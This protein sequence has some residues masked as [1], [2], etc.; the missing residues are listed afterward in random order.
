MKRQRIDITDKA[1]RQ[2]TRMDQPQ[3]L[4]IRFI[5]RS[6]DWKDP[7][8]HMVFELAIATYFILKKHQPL[9]HADL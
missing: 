4:F 1:L 2:K 5:R 8:R 7:T 6:H 9:A 3:T